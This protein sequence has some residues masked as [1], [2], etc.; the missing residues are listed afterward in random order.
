MEHEIYNKVKNSYKDFCPLCGS[1]FYG[2]TPEQV[3]EQII[4]HNDNGICEKNF[5]PFGI[6]LADKGKDLI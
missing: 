3:Y 1:R 6:A 2:D 4:Q 5:R